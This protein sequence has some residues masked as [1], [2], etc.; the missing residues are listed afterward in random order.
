MTLNF[1][2]STAEVTIGCVIV[3]SSCT[4]S[5]FIDSISDVI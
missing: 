3:N 5:S 4:A 1:E 2:E